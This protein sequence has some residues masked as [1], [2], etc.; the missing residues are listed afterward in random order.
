MRMR[1]SGNALRDDGVEENHNDDF[2]P[3]GAVASGSSRHCLIRPESES[4][5]A[6]MVTLSSGIGTGMSAGAGAVRGGSR[7]GSR[8][9]RRSGSRSARPQWGGERLGEP[10]GSISSPLVRQASEE[11]RFDEMIPDG[12]SDPGR[13]RRSCL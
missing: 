11:L 5:L 8:S 12:N 3:G 9:G 2:L 6:Q 13:R 10:W 4:E 1:E 7:S